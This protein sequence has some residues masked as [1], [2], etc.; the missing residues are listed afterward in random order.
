M[1][2]NQYNRANDNDRVPEP[3]ETFRSR[4]RYRLAVLREDTDEFLGLFRKAG[5]AMRR[6][7]AE[8]NAEREEKRRQKA[9]AE[10]EKARLS[11]EQEGTDTYGKGDVTEQNHVA[12][13]RI[14][15]KENG[16]GD[17]GRAVTVT[18]RFWVYLILLVV[19]F[20]ATQA[21]HSK[22][23]N[24]FFT[25]ML[26]LPIVL[27]LYTLTS[28]LSLFMHM[29][30]D[31]QTV[32]KGEACG[33]E[34]RLINQSILA[35]PFV[36]AIMVLPQSNAVRSTKRS[37]YIAMSP[38]GTYEVKNEL[39]FRFRGTYYVGVDC[40]FVYDFFRMFRVRV[41]IR[42][43][44]S[45]SVL[46]RELLMEDGGREAVS[47]D[48]ES[49][50]RRISMT[51]RVEFGDTR[52]YLPGDSLKSIHWNLSSR[53]DE[54]VVKDY[55]AGGTRT[56][57]VYCD[58]SAR[59]PETAPVPPPKTRAELKREKRER[60]EAKRIEARRARAIAAAAEHG[61]TLSDEELRK[62]SETDAEK[63]AK[64]RAAKEE[65]ERKKRR[66]EIAVLEKKNPLKA[67]RMR[68]ALSCEEHDAPEAVSA[69]SD[70]WE[71]YAFSLAS[72][73]CYE[74]MNE[75]CADGV[76]ELSIAV[77]LRELRR[78]NDVVLLWYDHRSPSGTCA[79][80][81]RSP[82]ELQAVYP[83]FATAPLAPAD[84]FVGDLTFLK[85]D[86]SG[87]RQIF[88]TSYMDHGTVTAFSELPLPAGAADGTEILLYHPD[89]RFAYPEK[90]RAYLE[91]CRE[92]LLHRGIRLTVDT[93]E[94]K[95]VKGGER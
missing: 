18:S 3:E 86:L 17:R 82:A 93:P 4:M 36:E 85:D 42:N 23:S 78:G 89:A 66:S 13:D 34:M 59:V 81:F 94:G 77:T 28:R 60:K 24:I 65:K 41:D 63:A 83:L 25:F 50:Q 56:T 27:L 22:A 54:L 11:E 92:E 33:Y 51:D 9:E 48:T 74:D 15:T 75:Y 1:A 47:D 29:V 68:D 32:H 67:A 43:A 95:V 10:A 30:S 73:A 87:I 61:R 35:Y 71:A 57:Y 72:D 52:D 8:R 2:Q 70:P 84:H 38:L 62:L 76:I 20:V 80:G 91:G 53:T 55:N 37:V 12:G 39:R 79:Y 90:R 58:L 31:N 49:T 19:A 69:P 88:V 21:L 14:F 6:R 26:L 7:S 16:F 45:V 64:K 5:G 46:P 40:F 44:I